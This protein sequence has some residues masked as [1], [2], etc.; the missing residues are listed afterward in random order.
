[1]SEAGVFN[2]IFAEKRFMNKAIILI[3]LITI[4]TSCTSDF[5]ADKYVV[6]EEYL[7]N[8][9]G[10]IMVDTMT[11]NVS[12][13]N[14]DSLITNSQE[15]I[16]VGNYSDPIFGK[17]KAQSYL[18]LIASN[19]KLNTS[20]TDY[21]NYVYDSIAVILRYDNYHYGDTLQN[22]TISI[23]KLTEKVKYNGE[24]TAFYN[25]STLNY[26][27]Q[28]IGTITYK[29][30]P[31]KKDSIYVPLSDALGL[32]LFQKL[33]TQDVANES[34]FIN[35]FK[36]LTIKSIGENSSSVIGFSVGSSAGSVLRLYYSDNDETDEQSLYKDF[37]VGYTEK[38]FNN[39]SLD[40]TATTIENLAS[41]TASYS[42]NLTEN[43]AYVQSGSGIVLRLDFPNI[44]Q[45]YNISG[46]GTIVDAQLLLRPIKNT[47][48]QPYGLRDSLSVF[49]A[50]RY[51]V[52]SD[53]LY[54]Y[55]GSQVYALLNGNSDEFHENMGYSI[56]IGGFLNSE[57]TKESDN[58]SSLLFSFPNSS[59]TVDRVVFG[60]QKNAEN[61][62]QLKIYY[63]TY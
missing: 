6:G 31:N 3:L 53:V 46:L 55:N 34:D 5:T 52:I 22:Q 41:G 56:S 26:D 16:L 19:Y 24:E 21:T 62:L 51:N 49:V 37:Y 10:V 1:M 61:K 50:N 12:T 59:K 33:K 42:S 58:K 25:T 29:P 20:S 2:Y 36:G 18:E 14:L 47:F 8:Q 7:Q 63:L 15:R 30:Q 57:L 40:R 32:E 28:S 48:S 13:V 39:I 38:Q 44:K 43:Q 4:F 54:D 27:T 11:V 17:L 35:Y 9:N 45:L 60:D 23:H